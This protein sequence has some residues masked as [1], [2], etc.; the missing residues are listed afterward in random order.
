MSNLELEKL[1]EQ[2][3]ETA[4]DVFAS[5]FIA[6]SGYDFD[7]LLTCLSKFCRLDHSPITNLDTNTTVHHFRV[8]RSSSKRH[9]T[10]VCYLPNK[11]FSSAKKLINFLISAGVPYFLDSDDQL[12]LY[13]FNS[14]INPAEYRCILRQMST[15]IDYAPFHKYLSPMTKHCTY[16]VVKITKAGK[17]LLRQIGSQRYFTVNPHRVLEVFH[18]MQRA[19]FMKSCGYNP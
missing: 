5:K 10:S 16:E 12:N 8:H 4:I 18:L 19:K 9:V 3:L 15:I 11:S 2:K 13:K 6:P 7:S 14:C 1:Q 17:V